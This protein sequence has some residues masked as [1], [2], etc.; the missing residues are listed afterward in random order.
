MNTEIFVQFENLS[1]EKL[2]DIVGGK[3]MTVLNGGGLYG[4]GYSGGYPGG[5]WTGIEDAVGLLADERRR[6]FRR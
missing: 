4:G 1:S 3:Q 2:V 5:I 6:N